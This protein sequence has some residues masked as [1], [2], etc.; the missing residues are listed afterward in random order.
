MS[1]EVINLFTSSNNISYL[2]NE[3]SKNINDVSIKD[4]ILDSLTEDIFNFQSHAMIEDSGQR[5]RHSTNTKIELKR[6]NDSF[7]D[8]R[9]ACAKNFDKYASGYEYYADQMFIDD[10]LKPGAYSHF[11]DCQHSNECECEQCKRLF[12]YQD[13]FQLNR[14]KIPIWQINSRGNTDYFNNDELRESERSQIRKASEPVV[15]DHINTIAIEC[16]IPE[17][18]DI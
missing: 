8:D 2:R 4:A 16:K 11:N 7:I 14:S 17:C 15:V 1:I 10:S 6:L 12:R 13:K 18:I 5:L 3:I 9:I